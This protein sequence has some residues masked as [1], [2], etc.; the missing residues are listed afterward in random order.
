MTIINMVPKSTIIKWEFIIGVKSCF[1]RLYLTFIFHCKLKIF[2]EALL[3][4]L[5]DAL[6]EN[7]TEPVKKAWLKL[8]RFI[9]FHMKLGMSQAENDK[10]FCWRLFKKKFCYLVLKWR[11]NSKAICLPFFYL[12][13]LLSIVN[14]FNITFFI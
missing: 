6:R 14:I 13:L 10:W 8:F 3:S 1:S 2:G 5:D 9:E 4:T 7:Y 11:E 12:F